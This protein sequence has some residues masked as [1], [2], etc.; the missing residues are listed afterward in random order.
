MKHELPFPRIAT[1]VAAALDR[2]EHVAE[3]TLEQILAA[4]RSARAEAM[5][6]C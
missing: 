1:A 2:T 6:C 3:P 4:D 5:A